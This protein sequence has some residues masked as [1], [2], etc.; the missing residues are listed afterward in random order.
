MSDLLPPNATPQERAISSS[1]ARLSE[2][3]TPYRDLWNP[4]TCPAS[5]LPW[6]AWGLSVDE[7]DANWTDAQKR[8]VISSSV[9]VHRKKGTVGAVKRVLSSFGL[10]LAIQEWWEQTPAGTPHTFKLLLSFITTPANIQ[11]SIVDAVRRVK[12][13][14]SEM[15]I[16]LVQG[17]SGSVNVVG[18]VRPG[19]FN[20]LDAGATYTP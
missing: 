16:E 6:I 9:E 2:V 4:A 11:D 7:W 1:T 8:S 17:F 20:R 5:L 18:I 13:V 15:I 3:P 12:P 14:R 19:V 10:G